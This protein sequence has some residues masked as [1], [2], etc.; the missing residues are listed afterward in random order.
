[1]E[2]QLQFTLRDRTGQP[3]GPEEGGGRQVERRASL[4][5]TD[6]LGLRKAGFFLESSEVHHFEP[7]GG[8]TPDLLAQ[9]GT[10]HREAGTQYLVSRYQFAE[11]LFDA[12]G[13]QRTRQL[14]PEGDVER[15]G[16]RRRLL[17]MPEPNLAVGRREQGVAG[18][19]LLSR[20]DI[21]GYPVHR[22]DSLRMSA[23]EVED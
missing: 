8:V 18:F 1:M 11:H 23:L 13:I 14:Q 5:S 15:G 6:T 10:R 7:E 17:L 21:Q 3:H 12:R 4:L 9:P 20:G 16:L 22:L 2:G 19:D